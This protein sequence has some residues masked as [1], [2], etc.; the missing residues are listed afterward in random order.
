ME[1]FGSSL[2][3]VQVK[4]DLFYQLRPS[5]TRQAVVLQWATF[6][7]PLGLS[8]HVGGVALTAD[9]VLPVRRLFERSDQGRVAQTSAL[10][11]QLAQAARWECGSSAVRDRVNSLEGI[12]CFLVGQRSQVCRIS[13]IRLLC[14]TCMCVYSEGSTSI[15]LVCG[16]ELIRKRLRA[17]IFLFPVSFIPFLWFLSNS[18]NRFEHKWH[19][20]T[21]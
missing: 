21:T 19:L 17:N 18:V 16:L 2:S 15:Q 7:F 13:N 6:S 12:F 9:P 10:G 5:L 1:G 14:K 11:L 4:T 20:L 3:R 8:R